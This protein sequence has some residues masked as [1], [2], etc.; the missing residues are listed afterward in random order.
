MPKDPYER[1]PGRRRPEK[2]VER[3]APVRDIRKLPEEKLWEMMNDPNIP[4][5]QKVFFGNELIRRSLEKGRLDTLRKMREGPTIPQVVKDTANMALVTELAKR[6]ELNRLKNG[7]INHFFS[8]PIAEVELGQEAYNIVKRALER[9]KAERSIV[10]QMKRALGIT[11]PGT[12][13]L[14]GTTALTPEEID[15]ISKVPGIPRK[16]IPKKKKR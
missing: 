6:N 11:S 5:E 1:Y 14:R 12:K 10:N 15:K 13:R 2:R 16:L 9:A 4:S 3:K 7:E 8:N